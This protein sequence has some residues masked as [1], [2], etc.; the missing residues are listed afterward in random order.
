MAGGVTRASARGVSVQTQSA[1]ERTGPRGSAVTPL[2]TRVLVRDRDSAPASPETLTWTGREE[3]A[4]PGTS[5]RQAQR[6]PPTLHVPPSREGCTYTHGLSRCAAWGG[7]SAGE[8]IGVIGF[9]S[10]PSSAMQAGETDAPGGCRFAR[11]PGLGAQPQALTRVDPSSEPPRVPLRL[12]RLS[13]EMGWLPEKEVQWRPHLC[14]PFPGCG[15]SHVAGW[16]GLR[17]H[18]A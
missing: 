11:P 8:G 3:T 15:P 14:T 6:G 18:L 9:L 17:P 5:P 10:L 16:R 13:C 2:P 4:D 7:V 1:P 12:A